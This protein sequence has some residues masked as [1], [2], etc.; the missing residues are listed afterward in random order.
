MILRLCG[1][2]KELFQTRKG[3]RIQRLHFVHF[4]VTDFNKVF[5]VL[6]HE[7][8]GATMRANQTV[9]SQQLFPTIYGQSVYSHIRRMVVVKEH[10][11]CAW[12][13]YA[14]N[15]SPHR[16]HVLTLTSKAPFTPI[17]AAAYRSIQQMPQSTQSFSPK[18]RD[19]C[20]PLVSLGC[21]NFL[22]RCDQIH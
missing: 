15:L 19:Q 2:A 22:S 17:T 21:Q 3:R 13:L 14:F 1:T 20:P 4:S 5:S 6:W 16:K 11:Q 7:N 10:A 12:C 18:A 9:A 8:P